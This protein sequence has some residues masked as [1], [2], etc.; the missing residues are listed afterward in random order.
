MVSAVPTAPVTEFAQVA[1]SR[2]PVRTMLMPD[3]GGT[4]KVDP[5]SELLREKEVFGHGK[6]RVEATTC[7]EFLSADQ[8]IGARKDR[9][10]SCSQTGQER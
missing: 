2:R 9:P 4:F 1:K 7:Q 6:F 8:Q 3:T 5:P 10:E